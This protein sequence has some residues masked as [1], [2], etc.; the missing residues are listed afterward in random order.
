MQIKSWQIA[1]AGLVISIFIR[2]TTPLFKDTLTGDLIIL[3]FFGGAIVLLLHST[4]LK[5]SAEDTSG[6]M[7]GGIFAIIIWAYLIKMF[8]YGNHSIPNFI[9]PF[10]IYILACIYYFWKKL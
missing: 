5:L 10:L 1:L 3:L 8:L 7:L 2:I 9:A 6:S 4:K